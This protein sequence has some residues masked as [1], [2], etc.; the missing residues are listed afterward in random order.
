MH[1]EEFK[2]KILP[3]KNKLYRFAW[4]YLKNK[5][6]AQD[7]V[8]EVLIKVWN[9]RES[10]HLYNNLEAWCMTI[11]K[12]LCLDKLRSPVRK[13]QEI[14]TVMYAMGHEDSP[15]AIAQRQETFTLIHRFIDM[16][17]EKQKEAIVLRDIN[18]HSYEEIAQMMEIELNAVKINIH[19][20]RKFLKENLTQINAYGL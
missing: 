5:E 3:V 2:S 4:F 6:E 13:G 10:W 7:V 17:P 11:T 14:E 20:G 16:L 19:R 1:L 12:N 8:Q 9:K 18:G 15:L